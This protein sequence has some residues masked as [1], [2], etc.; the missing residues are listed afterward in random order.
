[1]PRPRLLLPIACALVFAAALA[2][3]P[4][5]AGPETPT[6]L[7]D[8]V[9]ELERATAAIEKR[10]AALEAAWKDTAR[11]GAAPQGPDGVDPTEEAL[12]SAVRWAE[13]QVSNAQRALDAAATNP[14]A[15]VASLRA[16]LR[17]AEE[18]LRDSRRRYEDHVR[19]A[20][21]AK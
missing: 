4:S 3:S 10:L 21:G 11:P 14:R 9:A 1:M 16:T 15:D 7:A 5:I 6:P 13:D 20:R 19:A 17:L 12:R 18:S 2:S 8:R